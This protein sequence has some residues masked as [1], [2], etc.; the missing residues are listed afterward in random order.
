M[1]GDYQHAYQT[2]DN[3]QAHEDPLGNP[4]RRLKQ[5]RGCN[6]RLDVSLELLDG[7]RCGRRKNQRLIW[8]TVVTGILGLIIELVEIMVLDS[9]SG[10]NQTMPKG[11]ACYQQHTE[12]GEHAHR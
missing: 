4:A 9:F 1:H 2:D 8:L 12:R 6:Y 3:P 11:N 7:N 10:V 5:R